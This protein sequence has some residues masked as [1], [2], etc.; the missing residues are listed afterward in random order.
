[1]DFAI[2][3]DHSVWIKENE[4]LE[5]HKNGLSYLLIVDK[6][7]L[8]WQLKDLTVPADHRVKVK[9]IEMHLGFARELKTF[10]NVKVLVIL[11]ELLE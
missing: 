6:K 10:C 11:L 4:K 8:S 7:K 2:L 9:E 1:M 3:A 5:K